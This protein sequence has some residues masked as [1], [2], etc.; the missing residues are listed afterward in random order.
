M[1]HVY[2]GSYAPSLRNHLI[3]EIVKNTNL[4]F[5]TEVFLENVDD[6]VLGIQ[7]T[8]QLKTNNV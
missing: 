2:Q 6:N 1:N 5:E 4:N 8:I 7:G 3:L